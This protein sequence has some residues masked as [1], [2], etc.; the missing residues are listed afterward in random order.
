MKKLDSNIR[1]LCSLGIYLTI[2]I[3][4]MTFFV[5]GCG[6][7]DTKTKTG[8]LSL[9]LTDAPAPVDYSG[10]VWV[11]ITKVSAHKGVGGSE[12][13][14]EEDDSGWVEVGAPNKTYDLLDL[15]NC[16]WV[17]L[18][19][20]ELAIGHYTQLRLY[21]GDTNYVVDSSG[22]DEDLTVPSGYQ[23]GIKLI[24]GFDIED[25]AI[26]ELLLDF[27][28]SKSIV[29]E[30]SSG[31]LMLNPTIKVLNVGN[32]PVVSG[33]ILK[34]GEDGITP[35]PVPGAIVSADK[36]GT[37]F[38]G[39]ITDENG[40]YCLTLA[41]GTYDINAVYT[42]TD[43]DETVVELNGSLAEALSVL[44]GEIYDDKNITVALP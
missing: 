14:V 29:K 26:T 10:G 41:E 33:T 9:S 20:K 44:D 27:D 3:G 4:F 13:E 12:N 22:V 8:T 35:V 40:G 37:P 24:N 39:T 11:T 6:G 31:K 7:E 19:L 34:L 43:T 30:A 32:A 1:K 18:G 25:G 5:I 17:E 21:L 23:T 38:V 36:D 2:V 16:N 28:T 42:Y 15:T